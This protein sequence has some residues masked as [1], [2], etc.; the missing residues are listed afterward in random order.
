MLVL[1]RRSND[2]ISFPHVGISIRF[3]E[4][5][6]GNVK[7]E[8]DAP[9][10]TVIVRN[11]V[12]CDDADRSIPISQSSPLV[13]KVRHGIRNELHAI[14]LGLG[15]YHEEMRAGL[16]DEAE[17]TFDMLQELIHNLDTHASTHL[18]ET[19]IVRRYGR[20]ILVVEDD[21]NQRSILAGFLKIKGHE[22]VDFENVDEAFKYLECHETPAIVLTGMK[23]PT[24]DGATLVKRLRSEQ[25]HQNSKI[26]AI[27]GTSP[28]DNGLDSGPAGVDEWFP[29]PLNLLSLVQA[30]D[31]AFQSLDPE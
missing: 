24:C 16:I 30:I 14:S 13:K 15:L 18:D 3:V 11:G 19:S 8:I 29:K 23:M 26:F 2:A 6:S 27:C 10:E 31:E 17:S 20:P 5:N 12:H 1:S 22:V 28:E 21:L 7:V 4:I 25:R 9:P